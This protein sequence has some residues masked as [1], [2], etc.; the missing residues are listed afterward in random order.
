MLLLID[1]YDSF[2]FNL[3][4][5]FEQLGQATRVVRND[6]IDVA[7]IRRQRPRAIVIS[8]GPCTPAEAGCSLDVVRRLGREF[9]MLGVCLGHQAIA[10]ALGGDV[11]RAATPMHGRTS[12][13]W[14]DGAG[15]FAGL[16]QP[17]VACRYHS[18]VVDESTLPASLT[19][20][21]RTVDDV[22]MGIQHRELPVF[23]VQFH[24]EA[25]LT[26]GGLKLLDNFLR[27]A[28]I[29]SS[30]RDALPSEIVPPPPAVALPSVPV[31]F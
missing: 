12:P 28:G 21:A 1:N 2:V 16:P 10:A 6:A 30:R 13:V 19:V 8:P 3:A 9:P 18:L 25:I 23:G 31:T 14:H 7:E 26:E 15:L 27:L 22:V 5:Y 11:V 20:T 29:V 4:R 17:M 24:P